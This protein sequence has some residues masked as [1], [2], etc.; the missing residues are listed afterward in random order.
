MYI[1][2]CAWRSCQNITAIDSSK[3][4]LFLPQ[5]KKAKGPFNCPTGHATFET[6]IQ[7]PMRGPEAAAAAAH[8][9]R[10]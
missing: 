9:L 4:L 6:W 2:N 1:T 7:D 5:C 8:L 10:P 3:M